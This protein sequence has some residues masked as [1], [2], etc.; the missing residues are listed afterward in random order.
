MPTALG[1]ENIYFG[2]LCCNWN[3]EKEDIAPT[4][5]SGILSNVAL[6]R[7]EICNIVFSFCIEN[8]SSFFLY[9]FLFS[10]DVNDITYY[11]CS[12]LAEQGPHN[13]TSGSCFDS[14]DR[15]SLFYTALTALQIIF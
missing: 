7:W 4:L 8:L 6:M 10:I 15:L 3:S 2:C 1:P 12:R 5:E 11:K 9:Q 13:D 14:C